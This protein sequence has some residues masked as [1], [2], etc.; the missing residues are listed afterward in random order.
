M[1]ARQ[2]AST[3]ASRADLMVLPMLCSVRG[4]CDGDPQANF[5]LL[6]CLDKSEREGMP[7]TDKQSLM[8]VR[9]WHAVRAACERARVRRPLPTNS[10]LTPLAGFRQCL[11]RF[12]F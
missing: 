3:P 9:A 2:S 7:E 4:G 12:S 11:W 5:A 6:V 8:R 1:V 10:R